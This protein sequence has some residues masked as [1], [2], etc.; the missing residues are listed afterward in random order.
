MSL[1]KQ[2]GPDFEGAFVLGFVGL[3]PLGKIGLFE[4]LQQETDGRFSSEG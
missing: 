1:E 4:M 3:Y 2:A